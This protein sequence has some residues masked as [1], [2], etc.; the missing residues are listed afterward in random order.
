MQK[1]IAWIDNLKAICIFLVVYGHFVALA[2]GLKN[3][4]Y[5]FHL[6]AFLLITGYLNLPNLQKSNGIGSIK[7]Q[8]F[9][10]LVLYALFSLASSIIWYVLEARHLP[11][12]E[13]IK[14]LEGSLLGLHG[15][16]LNLIHNNDPLWY[17]PF[18]IS[19]LLFAFL[20][21]KIGLRVQYLLALLLAL[22][23]A[24]RY[25]PPLPWSLDLAPLG[26]FFIL[27]GGAFRIVENKYKETFYK[28]YSPAIMLLSL[29]FWVFLVW[30][31][32]RVNMNSREWGNSWVIFIFAALAG[33]YFVMC[34][35][36]KLPLTGIAHAISKHTLIIFCTH[37]YFVKALNN[38]LSALPEDIRHPAIFAAAIAITLI[39]LCISL[40]VQPLLIQWLKPKPSNELILPKRS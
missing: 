9:Y 16:E 8:L 36:R 22:A 12:T 23:Y 17:F 21:V 18:L 33:S 26:A 10:F 5:S 35:C 31:N 25:L 6:P 2:P 7:S 29:C 14:P 1:N 4:I 20:F 39:G 13:I 24:A 32:G 15:P 27:S 40:V 19:S 3:L 38:S 37:I 30:L 28:F 11:L 34:I